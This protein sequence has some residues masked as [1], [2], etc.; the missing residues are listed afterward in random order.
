MPGE[1][2]CA[3]RISREALFLATLLAGFP[4]PTCGDSFTLHSTGR[5]IGAVQV[6]ASGALAFNLAFVLRNRSFRINIRGGEESESSDEGDD[7]NEAQLDIGGEAFIAADEG[8]ILR[9]MQFLG[10][11]KRGASIYGVAHLHNPKPV[12]E[13]P[14][15]NAN[16]RAYHKRFCVLTYLFDLYLYL[17]LYVCVCVCMCVCM[18]VWC[19][20]HVKY[21]WCI[22]LIL[23]C[24]HTFVM[25]A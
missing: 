12:L 25:H 5:L 1:V 8:I 16:L 24:I 9:R 21:T 13:K 11:H 22:M 19:P 14:W 17:H 6:P 10:V 3:F 23:A 18:Y 20:M 15:I 2:N 4:A 7:H